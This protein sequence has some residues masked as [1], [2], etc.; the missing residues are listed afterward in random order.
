MSGLWGVVT[1]WADAWASVY[2]DSTLIE[3]AVACLH[4]GATL[5]AGGLAIAADRTTLR[6]RSIPGLG[7]EVTLRELY[8]VHTPVLIGLAVTILSGMLMLAA[9]LEVMLGSWVFWLKMGFF[10]VLLANGVVMRGAERRLA[11]A[12]GS[13]DA[14]SLLRKCSMVSLALWFGVTLTGTMLLNVS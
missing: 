11:E 7:R 8:A 5:L 3:N 13:E 6:A 4:V 1:G 14:W 10:V 12:P 9:D 2:N